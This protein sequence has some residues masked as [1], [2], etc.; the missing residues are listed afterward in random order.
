MG[1]ISTCSWFASSSKCIDMVGEP[2]WRIEFQLTR[3]CYW[4]VVLAGK[5]GVNPTR[6]FLMSKVHFG[7]DGDFQILNLFKDLGLWRRLIQN[8]W[9]LFCM[10]LWRL[11]AMSVFLSTTH[12]GFKEYDIRSANWPSNER[13]FALLESS[14]LVSV[15]K[16]DAP[17][18]VLHN[19]IIS[20]GSKW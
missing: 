4:S 1:C 7:N 17:Q 20:Y 15:S 10:C 6:F 16:M 3:K 8:V 11:C 9:Q 5:Y 14:P 18:I 19:W 12:S 2:K 13:T